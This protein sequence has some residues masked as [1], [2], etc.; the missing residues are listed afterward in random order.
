M[1]AQANRFW[2][3][4]AGSVVASAIIGFGPP[5]SGIRRILFPVVLGVITAVLVSLLRTVPLAV[6]CA[7]AWVAFLAAFWHFAG[8]PIG[9]L[10]S[11][12]GWIILMVAGALFYGAAILPDRLRS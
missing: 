7:V 12:G 2:F 3:F 1:T 8:P 11:S 5:S 9:L 10:A 6:A 4:L